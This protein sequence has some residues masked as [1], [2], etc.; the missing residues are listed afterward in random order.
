MIVHACDNRL[1]I[2][3]PAKLNLF[4]EIHARRDDGFHDL[5]T[6]M[7]TFSI[8]DFLRFSPT[9][10]DELRLTLHS[11]RDHEVPTDASNLIIKALATI[12]E[13]SG[14]TCGAIVELFKNIP[15]QA[16]LGGASGNAAAAILAANRMWKLNWPA[17]RLLNIAAE[18]GSDVAFFLSSGLARCTGR[19]ENVHNL[20]YPCRLN[21]VVAKPRFG[22]S[23]GEI[24][25]RSVV[26]AKPISSAAILGGL[27]SGRLAQVG[28]ALFNRLEESAVEVNEEILRL[29]REFEK[30]N[31]IGHQLT[32]SG[33]CYFGIYRN[34]QSTSAAARI[35]KNRLPDARIFA[36]QT[37]GSRNY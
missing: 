5:E 25:S 20:Y 19:G 34:R 15:V 11:T 10:N 23:T 4:L 37:P 7:T 33:S 21:A 16:G 17:K 32:G 27:K 6:V 28:R 26:P 22:I 30:T 1:S 29:R 12:R 36:G 9:S 24:Y 18:I 14:Q 13:L 3:S 2:A 8:F 31:C 35:L